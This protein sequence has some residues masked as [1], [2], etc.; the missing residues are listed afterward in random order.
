M[1]GLE[2]SVPPYL[3]LPCALPSFHYVA[4]Q[5]EVLDVTPYLASLKPGLRSQV[6]HIDITEWGWKTENFC[7]I[8]IP[9]GR[10][11]L[12]REG[13]CLLMKGLPDQEA[14]ALPY[15]T[16]GHNCW[17]TARH[18]NRGY[19]VM[20]H[21]NNTLWGYYSFLI[22]IFWEP[23]CRIWKSFFSKHR[24]ILDFKCA[25]SVDKM[26]SP[27]LQWL[28][29]LGLYHLQSGQVGLHSLQ[30]TKKLLHFSNSSCLPQQF[31]LLS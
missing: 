25:S 31:D 24:D 22:I 13:T 20:L 8:S 4:A 6:S 17:D 26:T 29:S 11:C 16:R 27:P 7:C 23:L 15:A 5:K 2:S 14:R 19:S 10:D 21:Q 1:T 28:N 12:D 18:T 30:D 3:P 9:V